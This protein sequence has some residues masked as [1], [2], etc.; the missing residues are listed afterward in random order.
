M[1]TESHGGHKYFVTFIDDYSRCCAVY[2]LKHRSE[3]SAKFKEFEAITTNDCGYKIEA[4]RTD[5]GGEY[6]SNEFKDYLKS[7]GIRHELT[8]PYTPEQNGVAER[9]NRTLVEAARSMMSHSGLS[10]AYWAEAVATAAYLRNR[11]VTTAT[12]K[13]PYE[14]WYGR[15]PD[16]SNLRVFGCIAYA[17][18]PDVMRHKLDKKAEKA[19]FVGYSSNPKGYRLLD[20]GTG[21]VIVR[22]DVTFNETDFGERAVKIDENTVVVE[23]TSSEPSQPVVQRERPQRQIRPP[24]RYGVDEYADTALEDAVCH[25]AFSACQILEPSTI[26]EALAS[27]HATE[28]RQA[29]DLE[30]KSLISNNTWELVELPA[31]RKPIGCKWVFKVKYRSDGEVERFKGRL[32]A[33]GYAQMYGI[34]YD[35]TFAP[36]VHFSSIRTLLAFAVQNSLLIHQ[37]D[38]VTAFLNG[39]LSEEIYMQQPDGYIQVGNEHLVCKLKKSL[40]GLKQ[41]PRC[42]NTALDV[43]LKSL[44]FM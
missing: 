6:I 14:R 3:V 37:M 11:S 19:R 44:D 12:D 40:Y 15:K 39:N 32:V 5:N 21:K 7:R 16:L 10:N 20:E 17:H 33:K 25:N 8:V 36:V 23:M 29:A 9:L 13:T 28:W 31:G 4:L 42:W 34:D 22:R 18:V 2:F 24:V 30:Y 38:V 41:S 26:D 43:Q 35:E 1:P 27:D